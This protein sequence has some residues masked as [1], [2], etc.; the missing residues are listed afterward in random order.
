MNLTTT[1]IAAGCGATQLRAAQWLS[2]IQAACDKYGIT[3]PLDVAAFLATLGV[4]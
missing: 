4:E 2:P 1:T 3:E